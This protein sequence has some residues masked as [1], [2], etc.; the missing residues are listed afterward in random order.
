MTATSARCGLQSGCHRGDDGGTVIRVQRPASLA[1]LERVITGCRRCPRLVAWRRRVARARKPE[2]RDWT[3]WGRPVPGFGDP[4]ARLWVIGLAPAAHG[5]N[6]TGRVFTGD[7]S[8]DWL[9]EALH[10]YGFANQPV[11]V[12]RDDGLR[13]I[14]CFVSAAAR[15]APPGN[16]PTPREFDNC[17][18]WLETER[19]LL[20][21]V[22]IVL[23]LGRSAFERYLKA[24][25]SGSPA[26]PGGRPR[27]AHG[28]EHPLP[29]GTVLLCSYHPSRRNTSTGLLR[30]EMWHAVFARARGIL[31]GPDGRGPGGPSPG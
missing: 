23:V 29:D 9:Y 31:S 5:G 7:S 6:R 10:R 20:R 2:F 16:K 25:G 26:A 27:F 11:S 12:A 19:R 4:G 13:L 24:A 22:R 1:A 17:R 30:R 14:D 15:C 8:G 18:P 3:Y 21:R 28:A